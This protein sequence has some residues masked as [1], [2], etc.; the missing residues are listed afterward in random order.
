MRPNARSV[1]TA[2][3]K[4]KT[5][6]LEYN[7]IAVGHG[8]VLRYNVPELVGRCVRV[9]HVCVRAL[10]VSVCPVLRYN[11]PE[12]VGRCVRVWHGCAWGGG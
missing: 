12:L 8:P 6:G 3:R 11:V 4:V 2:L 1:L 7:T 5:A 9:W 10:C